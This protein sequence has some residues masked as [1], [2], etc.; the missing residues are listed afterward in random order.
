[1]AFMKFLSKKPKKLDI[2]PPPP[3]L[4]IPPPPDDLKLPELPPMPDIEEE[5]IKEVEP[6]EVPEKVPE[7]MP[8]KEETPPIQPKIVEQQPPPPIEPEPQPE[9]EKAEPRAVIK[10][11][12]IPAMGKEMFVK[13]DKYRE[14]LESIDIVR[15]KVRQSEN[16]L[17]RMD[18]I[19]NIKDK[20][21]EK[22]RN[23][24]EDIERKSVY[25]D[26]TLFER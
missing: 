16:L 8:I 23:L 19:K 9:V 17:K 3:S 5:P 4:D 13:A 25:I 11:Q 14:I 22:W 18:E 21:F 6:H 26:K 20:E 12:K 7:L 24:L 15:R 10:E 2:P 1:M